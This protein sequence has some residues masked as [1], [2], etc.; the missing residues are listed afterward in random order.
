MPHALLLTG[1]AGVGKSTIAEA[2]GRTLSAAGEST[3]IVDVDQLAQFGPPPMPK[4]NFY[5]RLKC[6]NLTAVWANFKAAG[7]RFVVVSATVESI[8]ERD[9]VARGLTGCD[10]QTVRLV[11][12]VDTVRQ[13][14]RS[15][16]SGAKLERLLRTLDEP[17]P[18]FDA[19]DLEVVNDRAPTTVAR[20]ILTRA[21][22]ISRKA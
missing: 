9:D 14:L 11:A 13:R 1:V 20:E 19:A 18:A 22:W 8:A 4:G 7:A 3:A 16:D 15:R 2:I 10:V 21:G 12:D 6:A 17:T 5:H